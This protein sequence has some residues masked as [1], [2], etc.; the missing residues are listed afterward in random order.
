MAKYSTVSEFVSNHPNSEEAMQFVAVAPSGEIEQWI[1]NIEAW[2]DEIR[3]LMTA[4]AYVNEWHTFVQTI[5]NF[6]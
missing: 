6:K 4:Y 5:K 2:H 3:N 1:M